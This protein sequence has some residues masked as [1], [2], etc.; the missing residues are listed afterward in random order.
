MRILATE[1][2]NAIICDYYLYDGDALDILEAVSQTPVII[3]TGGGDE[4]IA[5][6]AMK[7]GAYEYLVKDFNLNYVKIL[8]VT[9][10]NAIKTSTA[11]ERLRL[12]ESVVVN[13]NDAIIITQAG[14][15]PLA[16]KIVYINEA[17]TQMTG[18]TMAEL[19]GKSSAIFRGPKTNQQVLDIIRQSLA[20]NQP[21]KAEM[22]NYTKTGKAF[23]VEI[24]IVPIFDTEQ[25]VTH[26]VSIQRNMSKRKKAEQQLIA[27][28]NIAIEAQKAEEHFVAVMSHEIRTPLNAIIGMSELLLNTQVLAEEQQEFLFTIKHSADILASL[29]NDVL[30]Y[31]KIK[32]GKIDLEEK[33]FSIIDVVKNVV[34]TIKFQADEKNIAL[35]SPYDLNMPDFVIGDPLRLHQIL[36]NLMSNSVKF[37]HEGEIQLHTKIIDQNSQTANIEFSVKDTGI[38]IPI[39]KQESIFGRFTQVSPDTNRKYGGTGLGLSIVKQLVEMQ[40][41]TIRLESAINV[42]STFVIQIPFK[43]TSK[44]TAIPSAS[45]PVK[46][47]DLHQM[48]IL[49]AEDNLINQRVASKI[50]EQWNTKVTI[51]NHGKEAIEQLQIH[52]YDL[53]LLDLQMPEMDGFETAHYIRHKLQHENQQIPIIALTAAAHVDKQKIQAAGIDEYVAKP[54]NTDQLYQIIYRYLK[55]S[56][57]GKKRIL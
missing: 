56:T 9:L 37:T 24:N 17:F 6:G 2:F 7:K 8:P 3:V 53:L 44:E 5:A 54:F 36:L 19:E 11:N 12:L 51:A 27:A 30:D 13:A 28:K 32:A 38:G 42:G 16:T 57:K 34:K 48:H 50:L 23:W 14:K 29:I 1:K 25:Q 15:D 33:T 39:D 55:P 10:E 43:I 18:Y 4:G 40:G 20:K 31:S 45:L 49:L 26:Y 41:G 46:E 21:I 22:I 52:P 35:S 47:K